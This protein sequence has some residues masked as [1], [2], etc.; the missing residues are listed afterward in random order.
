MSARKNLT[1]PT[2]TIERD[3][4]H[5]EM[6][7]SSESPQTWDEPQSRQA[8]TEVEIPPKSNPE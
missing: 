5:E 1:K 3:E 7:L 4:A 8:K 2:E 6:G